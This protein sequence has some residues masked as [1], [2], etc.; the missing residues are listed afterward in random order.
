MDNYWS[1][2]TNEIDSRRN[3]NNYKRV[4]NGSESYHREKSKNTHFYWFVLIMEQMVLVL[5]NTSPEH[6]KEET[7]HSFVWDYHKLEIRPE[8]GMK[9]KNYS[10]SL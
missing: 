1:N 4:K 2:V 6:K 9:E 7:L 10:Q 3:K 5:L 8:K